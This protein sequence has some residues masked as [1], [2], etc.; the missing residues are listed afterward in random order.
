MN[1]ITTRLID[2]KFKQINLDGVHKGETQKRCRDL[3]LVNHLA[4]VN[5]RRL[6][7]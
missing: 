3:L 1:R 2:V 7:T 6:F 4:G 5:R